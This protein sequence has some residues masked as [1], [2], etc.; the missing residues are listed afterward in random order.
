M[1]LIPG[2]RMS[3]DAVSMH[4]ILLSLVIKEEFLFIFS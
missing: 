4:L 2:F 3:V 1:N